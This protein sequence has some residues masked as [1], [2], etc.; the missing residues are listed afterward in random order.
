MT[1]QRLLEIKEKIDNAKTQQAEV[2]GQIRSVEDQ[3]F[4]KFEIKTEGA[5]NE[6][7]TKRSSELDKMEKGFEIGEL[8]LEDAYN[9][10]EW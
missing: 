4:T 5:A 10:S 3:M 1:T 6:Q 9:W 2:K 7:L 8:A